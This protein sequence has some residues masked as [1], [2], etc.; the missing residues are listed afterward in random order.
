MRDASAGACELPAFA[1]LRSVI[2]AVTPPLRAVVARNESLM[3]NSVSV[4]ISLLQLFLSRYAIRE[5]VEYQIGLNR[6]TGNQDD[7][8]P[9]HTALSQ[10]I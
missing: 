8:N 5:F 9:F 10:A 6:C 1:S 2:V 3:P 7:Q 4:S